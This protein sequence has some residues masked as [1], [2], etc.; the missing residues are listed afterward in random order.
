MIELKGQKSGLNERIQRITSETSALKCMQENLKI[1]ILTKRANTKDIIRE[2]SKEAIE[3][4]Q[5]LWEVANKVRVVEMQNDHF[6]ETINKLSAEQ[7]NMLDLISKR[8]EIRSLLL[9]EMD[10]YQSKLHID[11][12]EDQKLERETSSRDGKMLLN[13]SQFSQIAI[14]RKESLSSLCDSMRDELNSLRT[15]LDNLC[16]NSPQ[17]THKLL[18]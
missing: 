9:E 10:R 17:D 16:S 11:W 18:A 3:L 6:K 1:E 15:N 13:M 14:E 2:Y 8:D 5:A 7:S 12:R 4:E